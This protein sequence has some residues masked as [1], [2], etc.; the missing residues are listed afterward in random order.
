MA[1]TACTEV[2]EYEPTPLSTNWNGYAVDPE[3]RFWVRVDDGELVCTAGGL[4]APTLT[5]H[6]DG[7]TRFLQSISN[8]GDTAHYSQE[9]WLRPVN[10]R[11]LTWTTS[12]RLLID[13]QRGE[14]YDICEGCKSIY[15]DHD[16]GD[17]FWPYRLA[18]PMSAI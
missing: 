12:Y 18:E 10:D 8:Q 6:P 2:V 17:E 15:L 1:L 13:R 3:A 14:L 11:W 5:V 7:S 9:G 4:Q 16:L